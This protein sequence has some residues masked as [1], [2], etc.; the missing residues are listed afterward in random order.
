LSLSDM[1][2]SGLLKRGIM[3]EARN[4]VADVDIPNSNVTIIV[5]AEHVKVTFAENT[6]SLMKSDE[7]E[8]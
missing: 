4:V 5:K 1:I 6:R 2:I 3:Y 8:C 7:K